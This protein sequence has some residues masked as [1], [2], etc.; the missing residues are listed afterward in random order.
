MLRKFVKKYGEKIATLSLLVGVITTAQSCH[1]FF[2]QPEVP[3]Q[4]KELLKK[5]NQD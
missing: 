5:K 3:E 4:M 1:F 2:H